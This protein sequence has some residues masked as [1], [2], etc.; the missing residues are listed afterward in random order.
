M[1][2]PDEVK[3]DNGPAFISAEFS[4]FAKKLGF[5]HRL[6]TPLWPP[7]NGTAERFMRNINKVI[8]CATVEGLPWKSCINDYLA[9][10]R[11]VPHSMT[12][13]TPNH[14]MKLPDDSG[15]YS[16]NKKKPNKDKVSKTK[17]KVY[18]DKKRRARSHSFKLGDIV[19]HKWSR[20]NKYQAIFDPDCYEIIKIDHSM[21]TASRQDHQVTRNC[22]FFQAACLL[23]VKSNDVKEA[24]KVKQFL[25]QRRVEPTLYRPESPISILEPQ[26]LIQEHVSLDSLNN[27]TNLSRSQDRIQV[28]NQEIAVQIAVQNEQQPS[29]LATLPNQIEN[30]S[31]QRKWMSFDRKMTME[32]LASLNRP[33]EIKLRSR[34]VSK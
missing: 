1:G 22:F 17:M 29:Q 33:D 3:S 2:V 28:E 20:S 15:L 7:A 8:R 26:P 31:I 30:T 10:Y 4:K 27:A 32:N 11:N 16:I 9:N 25:V 24:P 13:C 23:G 21:I 19:V 34:N 18:T 5:T 6:I 14:L 12:G